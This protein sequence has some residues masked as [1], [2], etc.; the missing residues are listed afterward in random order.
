[1]IN[2]LYIYTVVV[3]IV[4]CHVRVRECASCGRKKG[5][6]MQHGGG[7]MKMQGTRE[8]TRGSRTRGGDATASKAEEAS[9][10]E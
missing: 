5:D 1:M 4:A 7:E 9:V 6:V 8:R 2:I 10:G 3:A